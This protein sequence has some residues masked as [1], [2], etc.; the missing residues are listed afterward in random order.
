[1]VGPWDHPGEK[2]GNICEVSGMYQGVKEH[3]DVT[4][5]QYVNLDSSSLAHG[6][7][8]ADRSFMAKACKEKPAGRDSS[9]A[10]ELKGQL[11][12]KTENGPNVRIW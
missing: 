3:Q 2:P 5:L 9:A 7:L 12:Q 6:W 8:Q 10:E 1:M 4:E 11:L